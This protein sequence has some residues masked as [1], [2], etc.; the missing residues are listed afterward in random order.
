LEHNLSLNLTKTHP[1]HWYSFSVGSSA[2]MLSLTVNTR[3]KELG[4]E[5]YI[6]DDK[7][8][9]DFLYERKNEIEKES[10]LKLEWMRLPDNKKASRIKVAKKF[11]IISDPDFLKYN[12]AFEWM[13]ANL[14][15]FKRV[16]G[17]HLVTYGIN[18]D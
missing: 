8:L 7:G 13:R 1:Q 4:C 18:Q 5:L 10:N 16:F 3:I 6:W 12:S 17:E 15:I 11:E 14:E 9:F 2:C